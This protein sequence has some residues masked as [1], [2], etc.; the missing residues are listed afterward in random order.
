MKVLKSNQAIYVIRNGQE[1]CDKKVGD[2]LEALLKA[3][4]GNKDDLDFDLSSDYEED[5]NIGNKGGDNTNNVYGG[6][7]NAEEEELFYITYG[8]CV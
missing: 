4:D 7:C 8:Y 2:L 1:A 6:L 3:D 5:N